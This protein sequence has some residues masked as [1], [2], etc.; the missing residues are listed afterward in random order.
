MS[1][2][3]LP[4]ERGA[5]LRPDPPTLEE[6]REKHDFTAED[7]DPSYASANASISSANSPLA[8]TE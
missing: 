3:A 4:E 7:R 5:D 6:L 1:R 2:R 8:R